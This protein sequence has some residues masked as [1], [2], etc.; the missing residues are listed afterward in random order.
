MCLEPFWDSE[1]VPVIK[2][3]Q[4][5]PRSQFAVPCALLEVGGQ[6]ERPSLR[7]VRLGG[8]VREAIPL[9]SEAGGSVRE[10]IPQ[11]GEVGGGEL[12]VNTDHSRK[13]CSLKRK[14]ESIE[15]RKCLPQS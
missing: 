2:V 7:L 11:T 3:L 12:T 6:S 13:P 5:L 10:A 1:T 9:V 8:S 14:L 4:A 15:P